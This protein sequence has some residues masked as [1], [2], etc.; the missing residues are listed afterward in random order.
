MKVKVILCVVL[1]PS[2][3]HLEQIVFSES[4]IPNPFPQDS[5]QVTMS[6]VLLLTLRRYS[7]EQD[8]QL[9]GFEHLEPMET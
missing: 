7:P 9:V 3:G 4:A 2:T 5:M 1:H 6:G 8:E